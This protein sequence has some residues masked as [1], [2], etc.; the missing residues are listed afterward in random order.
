MWSSTYAFLEG[1]IILATCSSSMGVREADVVSLEICYEAFL[2]YPSS[3][4]GRYKRMYL[5]YAES[6]DVLACRGAG[7]LTGG[8]CNQSRERVI[9]W[10]T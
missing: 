5:L 1:C 8:L 10:P 2:R 9:T 6:A 3:I 4:V 7:G